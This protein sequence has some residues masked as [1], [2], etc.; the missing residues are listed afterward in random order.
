MRQRVLY[1]QILHRDYG[2]DDMVIEDVVKP[3][4][5]EHAPIIHGTSCGISMNEGYIYGSE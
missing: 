2:L 5:A 4:V 3:V 1:W